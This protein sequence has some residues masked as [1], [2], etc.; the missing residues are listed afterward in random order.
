MEHNRYDVLICNYKT[1]NFPKSKTRDHSHHF[2]RKYP[3]LSQLIPRQCD[4][5]PRLQI[6]NGVFGLGDRP[7]LDNI[8]HHE[9]IPQI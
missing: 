3:G 5:S 4:T 6:S 8:M 7:I 2:N 9:P 1:I